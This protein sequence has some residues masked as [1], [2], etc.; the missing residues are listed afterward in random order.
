MPGRL[1]EP[2]RKSSTGLAFHC[3]DSRTSRS[4]RRRHKPYWGWTATSGLL[5]NACCSQASSRYPRP[6]Q[7]PE[8]WRRCATVIFPYRESRTSPSSRCR[9]TAYRVWPAASGYHDSVCYIL[10]DF[11][12]RATGQLLGPRRKSDR[13]RAF[14][15]QGN[16]TNRSSRRRHSVYRAWPATSVLR[17]NAC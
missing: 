11:G 8:P 6:G 13:N 16:R 17:R 1:S 10:P 5:R 9:N 14:Y 12:Y 4:S 15:Y 2:R 3:Q 7:R